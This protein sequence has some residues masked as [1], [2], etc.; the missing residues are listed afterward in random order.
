MVQ[1][2]RHLTAI[3]EELGRAHGALAMAY[4]PKFPEL[5]ELLPNYVQYKNAVRCI[6]NEMDMTKV[7]D[8]LNEI[9]INII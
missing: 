9:K 5:A 8:E 3:A 7:N 4:K 2:N 1:S 6:G